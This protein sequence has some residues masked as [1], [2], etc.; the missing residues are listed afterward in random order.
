[1]PN[2]ADLQAKINA[3][4]ADP[5]KGGLVQLRDWYDLNAPV[6][7]PP[8]VRGLI[9]AGTGEWSSGLHFRYGVQGD[10]L[11]EF[12]NHRELGLLN[13]GIEVWGGPTISD[14]APLHDPLNRLGTVLK[15]GTSTA[16]SATAISSR[17]AIENVRI[18]CRNRV[19]NALQYKGPNDKNNEWG[20]HYRLMVNNYSFTACD[21]QQ[22]QAKGLLFLHCIFAGNGIGRV[23]L[24]CMDGSFIWR[25]GKNGGNTDVDFYNHAPNE[26][27]IEVSNCDSENSVRQ[28]V[29]QGTGI[30]KTIRLANNRFG[31]SNI[32]TATPV[33][34]IASPG[35]FEMS[36]NFYRSQTAGEFAVV[37]LSRA[38]HITADIHHNKFDNSVSDSRVQNPISFNAA[39]PHN[40]TAHH[41]S[42]RA[43][44]SAG[45]IVSRDWDVDSYLETP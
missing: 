24:F 19:M 20:A 37:N 38:N 25:Y 18:E 4:C 10:V 15:F 36:G 3:A 29:I 35:P 14:A 2:E 39:N 30:G 16:L 7:I 12:L 8:N 17:P 22:S 11:L 45:V 13:F 28:F 42:Y 1:M 6:T 23:G 33:V 34:D 5:T 43:A 21:I 31:S 9:I 40:I 27:P 26:D 32:R 44:G 41:N